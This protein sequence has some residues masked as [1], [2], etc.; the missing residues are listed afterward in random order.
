MAWLRRW[1]A[2][3]RTLLVLAT[4]AAS[5]CGSPGGPAADSTGGAGSGEDRAWGHG[6]GEACGSGTWRPG[7]LE[8]HHL[9]LG[10]G[11]ATLVVAPT[12][13]TLLV[14]AGEGGWDATEGARALGAYLEK[15]LGCRRI[16]H[17]LLTHFHLDHVGSVGA[18]G[19]W[20]LVNVQGFS[21]GK[22]LHRD[23]GAFVGQTSRTLLGWRGYL[24]G[25]G[26]ALLRPEI[27]AQGLG[28]VDLGPGVAFRVVAVDGAGVL[29]RGDFSGAA[30]PPNE[31]DY[32]VAA[33][34]RFGSF[35]YFI[36]GDLSGR[37]HEG[38][39][40]YRYHDVE[41]RAA[42]VVGDVDVYRVNHH[43]SDHSSNSTFLAQLDPQVSIVSVGEGNGHGHP[44]SRTL[45]RLL[46]TSVVY[47]TSRGDLRS[48]PAGV[49][50]AGPVVVR[51]TDGRHYTVNGDPY[52]ATDPARV[53]DDGDGYFVEADP[54]D[55]APDVLPAP[56]GGCDPVHQI[57]TTHP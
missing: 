8:I 6:T 48:V 44:R 9:A 16:D 4:G 15:V 55:R 19:L 30:Q 14:D 43:G 42:R 29:R 33:V 5:G 13:R 52:L 23:L 17:V 51:T 37:L 45:S 27:A 56:N 49:R 46:A 34:L 1:P 41:T 54:D 10:Q 39:R 7:A 22:T 18:G 40:G 28:Q 36:G 12:G 57:C 32:S 31:N 53:D 20:H 50:V 2:R 11:E 47:L 35:D 24:A 21:V 38:E 26:R 25:R 3:V